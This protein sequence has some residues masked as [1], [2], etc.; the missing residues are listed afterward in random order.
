[1]IPTVAPYLLP[2]VLPEL[3]ARFPALL[4]EPREAVTQS[5]V[6]ETAAGRIDGFI[7]ALPLEHPGLVTV[8][9]FEDRFFLAV[10]V[11]AIRP[12]TSRPCRLKARR[13]SG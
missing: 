5:L 2:H 7:A 9:L 6:T 13:W 1:M 10:C 4:L 12:S 8:A 11:G 3:K